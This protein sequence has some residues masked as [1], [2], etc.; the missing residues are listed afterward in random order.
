MRDTEDRISSYLKPR[1][2]FWANHSHS[3]NS[4]FEWKDLWQFSLPSGG[5]MIIGLTKI[6][7]FDFS[8][9]TRFR[10]GHARTRSFLHK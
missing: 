5:Y 2:L 6:P 1:Q 10:I 9:K 7:D 8:Q 4:S 3:F